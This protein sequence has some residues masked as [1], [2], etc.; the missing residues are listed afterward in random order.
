MHTVISKSFRRLGLAIG[1]SALMTSPYAADRTHSV[2]EA[3][4]AE[5][6]GLIIEEMRSID[7]AMARIHS[8]LVIGAH[9]VVAREAQ[10]IHDSFVLDQ[11]LTDSQ[12]DEIHS[13]PGAFIAA[14][15]AFHQLAARLT[16]AAHAHDV[17]LQR[18]WYQEMTR[19]CVSCHSEHAA[20]RFPALRREFEGDHEH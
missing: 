6:R 12:R 2:T 14:D 18:F 17:A 10:R 8:A 15:G 4:S 11:R 19:A 5:T 9:E 16:Q 20:S 13:L 1:L 3:L 7:E